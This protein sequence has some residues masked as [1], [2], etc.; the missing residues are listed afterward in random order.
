MIYLGTCFS[1]TA[2]SAC[3]ASRPLLGLQGSPIAG[4]MMGMGTVVDA[5]VDAVSRGGMSVAWSCTWNCMGLRSMIRMWQIS[6]STPW[7]R[8]NLA[9]GGDKH[10]GRKARVSWGA[11]REGRKIH[12]G[13][14][15]MVPVQD[16]MRLTLLY[17]E[18]RVLELGPNLAPVIQPELVALLIVQECTV[19][20]YGWWE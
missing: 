11:G 14:A 8:V 6:L 10:G 16:E 4:C 2:K 5:D 15:H 19:S 1:L 17:A 13:S 9:G 18:C 12:A 7:L 3:Q 20:T